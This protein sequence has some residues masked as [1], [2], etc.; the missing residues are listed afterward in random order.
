MNEY[1]DPNAFDGIVHHNFTPNPQANPAQPYTDPHPYGPPAP[2]HGR[3]VKTGLTKRGK[4]ALTIGAVVLAGG[5]LITWQHHADT[6]A[7]NA[8]KAKELQLQQ[9]KLALE[10]QKA[11]AKANQTA[12]KTQTEAEKARQA[13]VD[14][15]VNQNKTLVGKQLGQTLAGVIS[16]CQ[17]QYPATTDSSAMQEAASATDTGSSSSSGGGTEGLLVGA[18]ALLVGGMWIGLRRATRPQPEASAPAPYPYP[19]YP[20][21]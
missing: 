16:D 6:A 17:N 13:K 10:Q 2:H 5:G 12:Q 20:H 4:T 7:A 8:L 18:G 14:A 21:N 15:C 19:Y 9:D 1:N 11:A 3:P